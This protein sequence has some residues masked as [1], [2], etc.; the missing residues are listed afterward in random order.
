MRR[1][2]TS[3]TASTVFF[4]GF[5]SAAFIVTYLDEDRALL[6]LVLEVVLVELDDG[7][8]LSVGHLQYMEVHL[9]NIEAQLQNI[10]VQLQNIEV[11]Q[12]NIEV[13]LQNIAAQL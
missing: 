13:Q 4:V 2:L 12:Q 5:L 7:A 10:E 11:Q 8:G 1:Y 6:D 3:W 9:Q